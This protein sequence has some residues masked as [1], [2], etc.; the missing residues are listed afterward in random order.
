MPLTASK[1]EFK[2][3]PQAPKGTHLGVCYLVLDLGVQRTNYNDVEGQSHK[4]YIAWELPSEKMEDGRP[5]VIGKEY[6]LVLDP[7]SNL[8]N[9]LISWRGQEFTPEEMEGFDIYSILGAPAMI[10]IVHKENKRGQTKARLGSVGK[11]MKGLEIPELHNP[12]I[13]FSFEDGGEVPDDVYDWLKKKIDERLADNFKQYNA[14]NEQNEST[15][16]LV[17]ALDDNIP[18]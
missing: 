10:T 1:G 3:F 11:K 6:S 14:A 2:E 8:Y 7:R 13:K 16:E 4:C 9:D 12:L 5:F 17:D 18:F 15:Q